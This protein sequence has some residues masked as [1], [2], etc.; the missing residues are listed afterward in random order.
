MT[1]QLPQK[2]TKDVSSKPWEDIY[3]VGCSKKR[4]KKLK[5]SNCTSGSA[6]E[7]RRGSSNF[8]LGIIALQ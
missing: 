6:L 1:L 4:L 2:W 3:W 5:V 7:L 8:H